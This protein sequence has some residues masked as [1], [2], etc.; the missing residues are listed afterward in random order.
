MPAVLT[1]ALARVLLLGVFAVLAV[2]AAGCSLA[3]PNLTSPG[4]ERYQRYQATRYDPY[5]ELD[6]A[7]AVPE[8]RPREH[9]KPRP[10]PQRARWIRPPLWQF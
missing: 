9:A 4:N 3:A 5:P 6:S 8:A 1:S 10:E 2:T 7:P